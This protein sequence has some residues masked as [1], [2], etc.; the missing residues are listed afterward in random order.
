VELVAAIIVYSAS[1]MGILVSLGEIRI[2]SIIGIGC[3]NEGLLVVRN[4]TVRRI[5]TMWFVS[6]VVGCFI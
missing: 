4:E 6:P 1:V 3:A 5:I 2:I